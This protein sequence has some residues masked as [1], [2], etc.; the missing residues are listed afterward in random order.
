MKLNVQLPNQP[1]QP[2]VSGPTQQHVQPTIQV[3]T[4]GSIQQTGPST[5]QTPPQT[6]VATATFVQLTTPVSRVSV[7]PVSSIPASV[8]IPR[9]SVPQSGPTI[10]STVQMPTGQTGT[11]MIVS[12][13]PQFTYQLYQGQYRFGQ[14]TQNIVYQ[15]QPYPRYTYQIPQQPQYGQVNPNY[16]GGYTIQNAH[17]IPGYPGYPPPGTGLI[18]QGYQDPSHQLPFIE[19][20]DLPD[21]LRLTNDPIFY[22]P[23]WLAMPNKLPS[24]ILKFEGKSGEDSSNHIMTYHL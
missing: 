18:T 16:P 24:D 8:Q 5:P 22:L 17:P 9:V 11:S 3:P 13:Q 7:V 23:Y 20:L 21:L 12:S 15:Y 4:P 2:I 19:T 10:Q 6:I 14:V 1:G